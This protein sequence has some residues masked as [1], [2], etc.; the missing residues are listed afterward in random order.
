MNGQEQTG[1][2]QRVLFQPILTLQYKFVVLR[3]QLDIAGMFFTGKGNYFFDQEYNVLVKNGSDLVIMN[4]TDLLF[5]AWDGP[6]NA[7]FMLGP[8]YDTTW[9]MHADQHW[10]RAGAAFFCSPAD[11]LSVFDHLRIYVIAGTFLQA[12][13]PYY[14]RNMFTIEGGF[15]SDFEFF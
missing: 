12:P 2:G 6:G 13:D 8:H 11:K 3:N 5:E 15:G 7:T 4:R 10:Q 1:V 9:S 14:Y